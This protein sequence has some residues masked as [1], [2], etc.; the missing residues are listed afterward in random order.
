MDGL[1]CPSL[2]LCRS[3]NNHAANTATLHHAESKTGHMN[4]KNK[5]TQTSAKTQNI[6]SYFPRLPCFVFIMWQILTRVRPLFWIPEITLFEFNLSRR[7]WY[8]NAGL[9]H[10]NGTP[11]LLRYI[12]YGNYEYSWKKKHLYY[13]HIPPYTHWT[14]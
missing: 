8:A 6:A 1:F 9:V 11:W 7:T 4:N 2:Y 3:R 12:C 5:E 14:F 13:K 10:K